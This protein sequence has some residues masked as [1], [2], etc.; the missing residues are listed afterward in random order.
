MSDEPI[1]EY[2]KRLRGELSAERW[3][4]RAAAARVRVVQVE[5]VLA[6]A[7]KG[8]VR[9]EMARRLAPGVPWP[10]FLHWV[11]L[12]R[13]SEGPGWERLLD[14][15]VTEKPW[16]TPAAWESTIR[17][18]GRQEPPPSL[19]KIREAL[20]AEHGSEA[21]LGDKTLRKVL[22][23]AGLWEEKPRGGPREKVTELPGGGG[24][25]LL[26]AA[27]AETGAVHR[28][29]KAALEVA[30]EQSK[31]GTVR[32]EDEERDEK[33][34]FTPEYNEVRRERY[35]ESGVD[36]VYHSV[37]EVRSE[38]DLSA[39]QVG[40]MKAETVTHRL[41]GIVS[42]PLVS[43]RRGMEGL[44]GPMGGW[45]EALSSYPYKARTEE[46]TLGELKL[47]GASP[48]LWGTHATTWW[49]WTR[50]WSGEG[51]PQMVAYVDATED[52]YWT[53]RFAASGKVARTGRVQPC[54]TRVCVSAGPGVPILARV[55]S[56]TGKLGNEL[57]SLLSE[58]D[59]LLGEGELGRLTV[60][61]AE[62]GNE[63]ML[64]LFAASASRDI[65]TVLKGGLRERPLEECGE[66]LSF[67]DRDRVREACLVMGEGTD[68]L[69]VRVVEM[70]REG[71]RNPHPTRFA[72]T[73]SPERLP[74]ADVAAVYLSR[75]PFL[76]DLFRRGRDA[77][78][79]DRSHGYGV[80]AVTNVAVLTKRE[81][82]D[83]AARKA[84]E[85]LDSATAARDDAKA[86]LE[87]ARA[88][89]AQ[90][91]ADGED[92]NAR[93]A[94][95]V[96]QAARYLK[97]TNH[98]LLA[99]Q[100]AQGH[101]AVQQR[102]QQT[103]PDE[104]YVR[105]T[106]LDSITTCLKMTL[107]ALLEFCCQ[108]Y[109]DGLRIMPRTFAEALVPLPVTI[110]ERPYEIIYE[111]APNPRDP[112]MMALLAVALDRITQRRLHVGK[113]LLVARFREAPA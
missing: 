27:E 53:E 3:A 5:A 30:G 95:G 17:V 66:W 12:Y 78:G 64:R 60:V 90:R 86:S 80:A 100:K 45:L 61:D 39:L 57:W 6:E 32:P 69:R 14:R 59:A 18:V 111:V 22:R 33:G 101:A 48:A 58:A 28:L 108:E 54:L 15:R 63:K 73:A 2:A 34:R 43:E 77:A 29:A 50:K 92:L 62:C 97:A 84:E 83:K 8:P 25:V 23:E 89:L 96:R 88:H 11:R 42:L 38:R 37:S 82:A 10:T 103:M 87:A 113:R 72:T 9:R 56:G 20:V 52:P 24:L 68:T 40:G 74:T 41:L 110:R 7:G 55:I 31:G 99:A 19:A 47:L 81:K 26:A 35:E 21:A 70:L 51:W 1:T 98:S 46:K 75:W 79:L 16:R 109:F 44:D 106:A 107:L 91:R 4:E 94:V 67:R 13:G 93:H 102:K 112:E 76:E 85:A 65:V 71:S 49:T 105:D 36:P 104:I